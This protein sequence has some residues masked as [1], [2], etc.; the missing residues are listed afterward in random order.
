MTTP[1]TALI[2]KTLVVVEHHFRKLN[3]PHLCTSVHDGAVYHDGIPTLTPTRKLRAADA[4][5]TL[6]DK[7]S[8]GLYTK[9]L[10]ET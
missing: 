4:I 2:W 5:Y 6:I 10:G 9:G 7:S 8:R 3:A 1:S